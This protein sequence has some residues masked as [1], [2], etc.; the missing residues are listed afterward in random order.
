MFYCYMKNRIG[1]GHL[2]GGER[3]DTLKQTNK[4]TKK[5]RR[6]CQKVFQECFYAIL[7]ERFLGIDH[8]FQWILKGIAMTS[9]RNPVR[10]LAVIKNWL[11]SE[12][13]NELPKSV[14]NTKNVINS[15][16]T[17]A[18]R[19]DSILYVGLLWIPNTKYT[20]TQETRSNRKVTSFLYCRYRIVGKCNVTGLLV[21]CQLTIIPS[22]YSV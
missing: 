4:Q 7:P 16:E 21:E 18:R 5:Q 2:G 10:L 11:N 22:W 6:N 17:P 14:S 20:K 1:I 8:S 15:C 19:A 13:L 3:V 12:T 9:V